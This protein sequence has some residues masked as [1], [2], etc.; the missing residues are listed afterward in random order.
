MHVDLADSAPDLLEAD[1]AVVGGGAAGLTLARRLVDGGRSVL[2]LESG[3]L[4]YEAASAE[5]N[6]GFN[7]GHEYYPL[8]DSRLRFLG[9]TTAIWGGRVAE[10]DPIDFEKRE[11]VPHS[12]WPIGPETL[13]P[14]YREARQLLDLPEQ[15]PEPAPSLLSSFD[16]AVI[17]HQEWLIDPKF[18]RFGHGAQKDLFEHRRLTLVT[19][20]TVG[21]IVA[22]ADGGRI[23]ALDVVAPGGAV[24]RVVA[25]DF[26][27]AAGGLENPRLL[28]ASRSVM[29]AG[30][31]NDRD[32][33]GRFFMEHPH[34]RGGRL[35]APSSKAWEMIKAF[36]KRSIDHF[37]AAA[38]VRPSDELQ[39]SRRILNSALALAVRRREGGRQPALTAAYL[40]AKHNLE[41]TR[42]GRAAWRAYKMGGR[43]IRRSVGPL[44][45]WLRSQRGNND[46][47]LVLRAEQAPNPDSRVML[48]PDELDSAGVPR[49]ALDWRMSPLDRIS[50]AELVAGFGREVKRL[51]IGEVEPADW[52]SDEQNDWVSD[53]LVSVHPLGGYHH[54]GTTRMADDP[55]HGV[56]DGHGRVHGLPNLWIAGSSLFPTGGWAN[57][58]L[59][60]LA[61]A[62]R[63]ADRLLGRA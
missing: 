33:V 58:T 30:I 1:V 36:Q 2:L 21:E 24:T 32:L 50:A 7:V 12:G 11:W 23:E 9:G 48:R 29:P 26:V 22:A 41:P 51:G 43:I 44:I 42:R 62:L 37:E 38:L 52:L 13:K 8:E 6:R 49:I 18:D 45:W 61:L 17:A 46:L 56:T 55:A 16:P 53:P 35:L 39:R 20:A 60:I 15:W 40:S 14:Y 63:Q 25:H 34:G 57:P 19:H 28:L 47:A 3:G 59:T 54:M 4:D 5:L 27:L 31:G 10:L